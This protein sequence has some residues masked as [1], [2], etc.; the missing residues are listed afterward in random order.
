MRQAILF[1][2]SFVLLLYIFSVV[3]HGG[4]FE[5][6]ASGVLPPLSAFIF[7]VRLPEILLTTADPITSALFLT[8]T[9]LAALY[10]S[11]FVER[12][13][14]TRQIRLGY[15]L[16]GS[17]A[18]VFSVGCVACGAFVTPVALALV[19]GIPVAL[20]GPLHFFL[21]FFASI[22]L[23]AGIISLRQV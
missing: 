22:L 16:S 8:N 18:A 14:H 21:G 19:L 23:I 3:A 7:F 17:L 6:M 20:L 5:L 12:F 11:M 9:T 15:G 1:V 13:I 4:V 10:L 2:G